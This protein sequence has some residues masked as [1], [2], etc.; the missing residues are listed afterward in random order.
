[1]SNAVGYCDNFASNGLSC[2]WNRKGELIGQLDR[3]NQGLLIYDT[4]IGL[5]EVNQ[6]KIVKGQVSDLDKLFQVY[7]NA[8]KELERSGIYQ[9]VESYP[10]KTIIEGDL[11]KGVLFLLKN[12][13]EII[14]AINI[15]EEQEVEYYT[16]NW[17]F[18]NSRVVVIHRL[19][20]DPKYQRKG[21]A[22]LLMDFA[23]NFAEKNN[24]TL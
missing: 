11:K 5:T 15:S 13:T 9:W 10:T 8:K 20:I 2:V 24:Y 4:E 21:Y 1:M 23:E 18:D 17:K 19:V 16:V 3:E 7:K 6:P 14:G 22:R 12:G